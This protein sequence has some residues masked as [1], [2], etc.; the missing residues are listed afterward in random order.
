M[1]QQLLKRPLAKQSVEKIV[2]PMK[3]ILDDLQSYEDDHRVAHHESTELSKKHQA[4]ADAHLIEADKAAALA[5][6]YKALIS[7]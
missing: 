3:R 4:E 1:A 5:A 2:S 6:S 7:A